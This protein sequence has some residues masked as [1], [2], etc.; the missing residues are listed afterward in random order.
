M[1]AHGL[2]LIEEKVENQPSSSEKSQLSES[3]QRWILEWW[4]SKPLFPQ[5]SVLSRKLTLLWPKRQSTL[6]S[7]LRH[8][9]R[10][11][12]VPPF[13]ILKTVFV[14]LLCAGASWNHK[15]HRSRSGKM[16]AGLEILLG[17]QALSCHFHW[18]FGHRWCIH[19]SWNLFPVVFARVS[20][21]I[22]AIYWFLHRKLPAYATSNISGDTS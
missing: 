22:F 15:C 12:F 3:H 19:F 11:V 10:I 2:D 8:W 20:I 9:W 6:S 16:I 1:H 7:V 17:P 18:S 4:N 21:N 5:Q 14:L 13:Q